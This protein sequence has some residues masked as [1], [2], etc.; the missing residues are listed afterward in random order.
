[1]C[2]PLIG[3]FDPATTL[4]RSLLGLSA[5]YP[6]GLPSIGSDRRLSD[7]KHKLVP[8]D[9][10]FSLFFHFCFVVILIEL[11]LWLVHLSSDPATTPAAA[12]MR[13]ALSVG[14]AGM[15][16]PSEGRKTR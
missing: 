16:F 14:G 7:R 3:R 9:S 12:A 1:M 10:F 5:H 2:S 6:R 8:F 11:T 15:D 4:I 13:R